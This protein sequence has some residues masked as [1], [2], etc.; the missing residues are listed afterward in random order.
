ME[1][2][3]R[4][5]CSECGDLF[6]TEELCI[7]HEKLHQKIN[8]ANEM[9]NK[10][11]TLGEI[12]NECNIWKELPHYLQDV[13]IDNCFVISYLQCCSKPAYQIVRINMDRTLQLFGVGSYDGSITKSF[14]ID[15]A[16]LRDPRE[17]NEL[18]VYEKYQHIQW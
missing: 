10:K 12:Q 2:V 8:K 17:N 11:C 4:F 14:F 9:L 5:R 1:K 18:Y 16:N 7:R 13:N 6:N 15:D 3:L